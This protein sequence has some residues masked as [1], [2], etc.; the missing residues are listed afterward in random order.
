MKLILLLSIVIVVASLVFAA[1]PDQNCELGIDPCAPGCTCLAL[2]AD[3]EEIECVKDTKDGESCDNAH[4]KCFAQHN[5]CVRSNRGGKF[6]CRE[7]CRK[8]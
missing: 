4:N 3:P 7:V 6:V 1:T 8:K 2:A 5:A